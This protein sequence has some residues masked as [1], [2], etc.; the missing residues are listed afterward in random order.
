MYQNLSKAHSA[1]RQASAT[2]HPAIA[3]VKIYD[4]LILAIRQAIRSL[5]EKKHEQAFSKVM[6]AAFILRG[7]IAALDMERGG[8]VSKRL[9]KVYTSYIFGLHLSYGKPD[10]IRR[11]SKLLEGLLPMREAWVHVAK[12]RM[13]GETGAV[14][15]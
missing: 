13:G 6:R 8:A 9:L 10:V 7:L 11:Y 5:E 1:Y 15:E 2:V 14:P 12:Y 3:Q 4:E